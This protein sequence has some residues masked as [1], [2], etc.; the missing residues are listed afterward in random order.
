MDPITIFSIVLLALIILAIGYVAWE[1]IQTSEGHQAWLETRPEYRAEKQVMLLPEVAQSRKVMA[2]PEKQLRVETTRKEEDEVFKLFQEAELADNVDPLDF[3][4]GAEEE[5]IQLDEE[6]DEQEEIEEEKEDGYKL[7][8][9]VEII[10]V[11]NKATALYNELID[12]GDPVKIIRDHNK[13]GHMGFVAPASASKEEKAK[14]LTRPEWDKY[15]A[16]GG[17]LWQA[18]ALMR[19]ENENVIFA[20]DGRQRL[21]EWLAKQG[22]TCLLEEDDE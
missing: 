11:W 18:G 19:D 13:S 7:H 5:T 4:L 6:E 12:S 9:D 1:V 8:H 20:P 3:D 22:N 10:E 21:E 17:I 16:N 14:K 2:L 15:F